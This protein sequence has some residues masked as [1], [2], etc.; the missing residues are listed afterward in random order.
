MI[1]K[2]QES[3][4]YKWLKKWNNFDFISY[5]KLFKLSAFYPVFIIGSVIFLFDNLFDNY[6]KAVV[7]YM[8]GN[9]TFRME[10]DLIFGVFVIFAFYNF[11]LKIRK[12]SIPT[13]NS[14]LIFLI[15]NLVYFLKFKNNELYEYSH[16][17]FTPLNTITHLSVFLES[18]LLLTISYKTSQKALI[19][20][21]SS[22]FLL[23]DS[24][25]ISGYTDLFY[26][27]NYANIIARHVSSTSTNVSFGI[28]ILG[29]WGAGKSDFMKRI[30]E[31]LSEDQ[32]NIIFDFNPWRLNKQDA[33]VEEFFTTLGKHLQPYSQSIL[34]VIKDYSD[35]LFK[36]AK[37]LEFRF[38]NTLIDNWIEK[39]DIQKEYTFIDNTIK[40][41]GKRL[42]IFLDDTDRLSGTEALEVLRII[43][44]TA[45]FSNTFYI[46]GLDHN[47]LI[48]VLKKTNNFTNE[49]EYLK[50]IFQLSITLPTIRKDL[51]RE[52]I[53]KHLFINL[54]SP[55]RASITNSLKK[56]NHSTF[57]TISP[58]D[59]PRAFLNEYIL[60]LFIDNIRDLK[61]FCNS[62]K[63]IFN[64]LKDESEI[65]DLIILE[66]I[67]NKNIEVY[68]LIRNRQILTIGDKTINT[69]VLKKDVWKDESRKLNLSEKDIVAFEKALQFIIERDY[70]K[71]QRKFNISNN[72]YIYFSYQLFNLISL[73]EFNSALNMGVDET[74]VIFNN[75]IKEE[76]ERELLNLLYNV[77]EGADINQFHKIIIVLLKLWKP[78]TMWIEQAKNL[79]IVSWEVNQSK[80]F[81]NSYESHKKF[82]LSIIEHDSIEPYVRASLIN[83]FLRELIINPNSKI[84]QLFTR[85][86]LRRKIYCLFVRHLNSISSHSSITYEFYQLND[87]KLKVQNNVYF[88]PLASKTYKDFLMSNNLLF[89]IYTIGVLRCYSINQETFFVF[90]P[91]LEQIFI[92]WQVFEKTLSMTNFENNDLER[93]KTI[94]LLYLKKYFESGK[95]QFKISDSSDLQFVKNLLKKNIDEF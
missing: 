34:H 92:D 67:R 58:I 49:A 11:I 81:Q 70:E 10:S 28:G 50:K 20:E 77:A 27:T 35:R 51:F 40:S 60:E 6:I 69:W 2:I 5:I 83:P 63:I 44:N 21:N 55:D 54:S 65:Q 86:E 9:Y 78:G 68:N 62:F 93:L 37:Q 25:E 76:K 48:E 13:L 73:K 41:T 74:V 64:I 17:S 56:L 39:N 43:R 18:V 75:F 59:T 94:I 19:K 30:K 61:R 22:Y 79:I 1:K 7:K 31:K 53:E 88:I 87:Y 36:P 80:Y 8:F 46:V 52:E 42:V 66:L 47:Y 29:D 33:I 4:L 85:R 32:D 45:N 3:I 16:F 82:I 90:D 91:Y 14:V 24:T 95:N 84:V 71:N 15:I 26:R 89:S 72:F 12:Y 57:G 38:L 23:D